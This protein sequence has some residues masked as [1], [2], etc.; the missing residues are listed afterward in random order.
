MSRPGNGSNPPR[1]HERANRQGLVIVTISQLALLHGL[2]DR[3]EGRAV[4]YRDWACASLPYL[5][6]LKTYASVGCALQCMHRLPHTL[7]T[8]TR[9]GTRVECQLTLRGRALLN[10]ELPA[11][12]WAH[13][14]Y[15]GL[16]RLRGR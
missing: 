13:G 9:K 1:G 2:L 5:R 12:V 6:R 15:S 7:V 3:P 14:P 4:S 11:Y 8:R 10:L 16:R